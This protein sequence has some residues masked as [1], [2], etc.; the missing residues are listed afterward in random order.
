MASD[1]TQVTD[2]SFEGEVLQSNIPV[3]V[4]FWAEW[5]RPCHVLAPVVEG[6]AQQYRGRLKVVKLN[7]DENLTTSGRYNIRGIPTLLLF[8]AGEIKDQIVGAVPKEAVEKVLERHLT[9]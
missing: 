4:D 8:K 6:I 2:A 1:V 5:C 3:L 7:V 9:S